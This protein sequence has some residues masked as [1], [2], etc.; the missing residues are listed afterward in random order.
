MATGGRLNRWLRQEPPVHS[1]K[2]AIESV[3][4]SGASCLIATGGRLNRWLR[5]EPPVYSNKWAIES[6]APSGASCL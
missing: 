6:M 2:W 5:Q 1:N 3:A 4:P